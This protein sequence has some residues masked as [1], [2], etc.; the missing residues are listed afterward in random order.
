[1]SFSCKLFSHKASSQM[2]NWVLVHV[3]TKAHKI[4]NPE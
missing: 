2:F 1:M 3:G 4:M